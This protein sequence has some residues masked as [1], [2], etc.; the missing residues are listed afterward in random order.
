M[1][2]LLL[3]ERWPDLIPMEALARVTQPVTYTGELPVKV[4]WNFGGDLV[5]K[6]DL[7]ASAPS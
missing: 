3:D 2:V 4:R 5:T 7:R 6:I 1:T